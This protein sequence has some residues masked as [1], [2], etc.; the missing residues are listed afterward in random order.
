MFWKGVLGYLPVNIVQGVVGL[1][2]IVAFTRML[3]PQQYGDYALAL[4][5]VVLFHTS[6]F[7]WTEA[8]MA[9][10]QPME[11]KAGGLA[12]HFATLYRAWGVLAVVL[13]VLGGLVVAFW[14]MSP[15]LKLAVGTGLAGTVFKGL[16]RLAQEH[17]RAAGRVGSAAAID[18]ILTAGGFGGGVILAWVGFG[19]AAPL[20]GLGIATFLV[21][22]FV[23]PSE[24]K[25]MKSG[26]FEPARAKTYAAYGFPLAASL[27]LALVL[28]SVDRLLIGAFLDEASVGVYHA[29]YSLA[30]RTLDV[31]FIWLGSA[32]GPAAIAALEFGGR[33]ALEKTAREQSSFML[34]LTLPAAVGLAL[35]AHPLAEVLVGP[36][37]REGAAHVTPWIAASGLFAGLTTYY[38]HTA[39]TL[40]KS[41]KLLLA[42]MAVPAVANIALNLA[43]IP[44]FGLQGA[45]IATAASYGL[46]LMASAW[47]GR[48]AIV[49]PIPWDTLGRAGLASA[50][51]AV[52][53]YLIPDFG[54]I[55]ELGLKASVGG[56]VYGVVALALNAGGARDQLRRITD[57][58][59]ARTVAA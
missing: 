2:T 20:T 14:P 54:G 58:L 9:R 41:T 48:K 59:K 42:A 3:T 6:L 43:L 31:M 52:A 40:A 10:F 24:L 16:A 12:H 55:L 36:A 49:L 39:F 30:N 22:V 25:L 15:G 37:L 26:A 1:L 45:V 8:A 18:M 34:L 46:G 33:P 4:S 13:I 56:L 28:N 47:I 7:T 29:G 38:F 17:R 21:L 44:P 19:G 23:L 53:V 50:V 51:M 27:I 32:A 35:V 5:V 11:A 57:R